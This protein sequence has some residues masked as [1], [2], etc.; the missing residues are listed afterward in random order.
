ML[1]DKELVQNFQEGVKD[2]DKMLDECYG[3]LKQNRASNHKISNELDVQNA[4]LDDL[5]NQM[6]KVKKNIDVTNNKLDKYNQGSSNTW[7]VI[8]I[9]L[10]LLVLLFLF[11]IF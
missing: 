8:V 2:Q 5:G 7:L 1:T 10:E 11:V 6:G 4:H 3:L 9:C